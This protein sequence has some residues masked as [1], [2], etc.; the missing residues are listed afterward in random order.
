MFE[1]V[2]G[3]VQGYDMQ[4]PFAIINSIAVCEKDV[5]CTL[6]KRN[7]GNLSC[8]DACNDGEK[9]FLVASNIRIAICRIDEVLNLKAE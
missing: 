1:I 2:N 6:K 9:R 4:K 5:N 7:R 3:K 8:T